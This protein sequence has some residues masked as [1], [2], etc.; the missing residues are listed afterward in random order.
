MICSLCCAPHG[1]R[2]R[3]ADYP[4][5]CV[6]PGPKLQNAE[7]YGLHYGPEV[8][9]QVDGGLRQRCRELGLLPRGELRAWWWAG[10]KRP[11]GV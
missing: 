11:E 4:R 3:F 6:C 8:V 5:W 2:V 9:C 10:A 7:D 1:V